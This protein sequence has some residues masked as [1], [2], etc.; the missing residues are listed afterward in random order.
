MI[1]GLIEFVAVGVTSASGFDQTFASGILLFVAT[2]WLSSLEVE[3]CMLVLVLGTLVGK[4]LA[5]DYSL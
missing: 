4:W 1:L 2:S 3:L 5:L